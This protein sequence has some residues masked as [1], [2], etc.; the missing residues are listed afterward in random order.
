M[1]MLDRDQAEAER[2][3][4]SRIRRD[5]SVHD[6]ADYATTRAPETPAGE[7]PVPKKRARPYSRLDAHRRRKATDA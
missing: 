7:K 6:M 4:V 5:R 3:N 2:P 1:T